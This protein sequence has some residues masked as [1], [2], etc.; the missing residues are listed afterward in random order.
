MRN[1]IERL[2][3]SLPLTWPPGFPIYVAASPLAPFLDGAWND[4]K[5][6]REHPRK[7]SGLKI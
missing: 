6:I 1:V 4:N 2:T 7:L 5:G 3:R